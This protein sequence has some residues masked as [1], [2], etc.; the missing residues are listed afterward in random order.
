M[1]EVALDIQ[2]RGLKTHQNPLSLPPGSLLRALNTVIDEENIVRSARGSKPFGSTLSGALN[3]LFAYKGQVLG[4]YGTTL[5][6]W[7]LD[8][9][10][11]NDY[12][13]TYSAPTGWKIKSMLANRNFYFT[14]TAG[15]KKLDAIAGTVSASGGIK[16]LDGSAALVAGTFMANN[17]SVA[18]RIVWGIK[19]ANNNLILG[20]PSMRI[21]VS[22]A[23]GGARDVSLTITIPDGVTT[24]HFYQVYRSAQTASS[25]VEANDELQQ[26]FEKNPTSGEIAAKLLTVTDSTPDSL[27]GA[28]LYTN[29]SQQ[30]IAQANEPPPLC[31][32]MTNFRQMA[33]YANTEG[34]QRFYVSLLS[35]GSTS[36]NYFDIVG[37]TNSNTTVNGIASTANIIAGQLITGTNI[38]ANTTVVSVDSGVSI[39]ISQAATGTTVG[40]TFR[41]RDRIT[42]DGVNFWANSAEDTANQYF[43]V[44]TGGTVAQNIADTSRSLVKVVNRQTSGAIYGYYL[45]GFDDLP[46]KM[47]FEDRSLGG[48]VWYA[49]SSKGASWSPELANSGTGDASS[50][51][52]KKNAIF[53]S[54]V[55]QPESV[56]LLNYVFA[57]SADEDIIRIIATRDSAFVLKTDGIFRITGDSPSTIQVSPFD[58]TAVLKGEETAVELN[59]QIYGY[60]DQGVSSVSDSGVQVLSRDVEKDLL[61]IFSD[62]YT[63]AET[64]A[65]GMGY[66]SE[67]KYLLWTV[68]ETGDTYA[69]QAWVFNT[70]TNSWTRW[71]KNRTCGFINSADDKFYMGDAVANQ[72][73]VERKT[74]TV[75]DFSEDEYALTISAFSG[76]TITVSSTASAVAG[77]TL[78]QAVGS[79]LA[80]NQAKVLS[81]TDGTHLVVDRVVEWSIAAAKL[82]D[83]I[84]IELEFAPLHGGQPGLVKHFPE[85]CI[86]VRDAYF[87]SITLSVASNFAFAS[88]PA[89]LVP[90]TTGAWGVAGWGS[91]PWG[92]GPPPIQPMRTYIPM[93]QQ[94]ANW[95]NMS[96][97]HSEALT[98]LAVAGL[99]NPLEVSG[100]RFS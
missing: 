52:V 61:Q 9:V 95:L 35:V 34:P 78:G 17:T 86:F 57:G 76:T 2:I 46:G 41:F 20:S 18:Y 4:H 72:I 73:R 6:Y 64:V 50:S 79:G 29:P 40:S 91:F 42:L 37:N 69:K 62:L 59:N 8:G 63:N 80:Y 1:A 85:V 10:T 22:N 7:S 100:T 45:S 98:V 3:K 32:D 84:P 90:V 31:K 38:P 60:F 13:G 48:S 77:Q 65:F 58:N 70:F 25:T 54:K 19:D 44:S 21:T 92:G 27:R 55:S 71:E 16:A 75:E 83:P 96:I 26:V 67:R 51:E 49:T 97:E 39:T 56:P 88:S 14:T 47:L 11:R 81:I 74:Y 43:Q 99:S 28:S 24:S 68:K 53:I 36:M 33:L 15:V 93:E 66:E 30:G 5:A 82:Y 87:R 89:M 94:R 12:A 23:S